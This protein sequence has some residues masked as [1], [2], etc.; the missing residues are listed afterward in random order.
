MEMNRLP[1]LSSVSLF[2]GIGGF[3]LGLLA[4][5]IEPVLFCENWTFAEAVLRARFPGVALHDDVQTLDQ[6]PSC[7]VVTAGFPCTDLSQAGKMAGIDGPGSG[8]VREV[9]RLI[10]TANNRLEWLVLENV[11]NMLRLHR[12]RAMAVIVSGLEA[13]G[14]RWAYR[15]VDARAFGLAQRRRRV[16]LV[17]SPRHDPRAVLFADEAGD[18]DST[19]YRNDAYGFYW[20]E[21]LRG[22]GWAQDAIPTLKG[23]STVGIVSPPASWLPTEP[24]G[25]RIVLP[26]IEDGEALQGFPRGWTADIGSSRIAGVRWKLVGNAVPVPMAAWVGSRIVAPGDVVCEQRAF[27]PERWPAAAWGDGHK[28]WAVAASTWPVRA[29]YRH[30]RDA[31]DPRSTTPLSTRATRGFLG[32]LEASRLRVAPEE[33]RLDVKLHLEALEKTQDRDSHEDDSSRRGCARG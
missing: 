6:L 10:G 14:W 8:L 17:A 20:T 28:R 13:I 21:G 26:G 27:P 16:L 22:L 15:T 12:G 32:R 3:D 29:P 7:E 33:F 9:L 25:R 18:P 11:A 31:L 19:W 24:V 2:A 1:A 4:S 23:G 5:G 30:L